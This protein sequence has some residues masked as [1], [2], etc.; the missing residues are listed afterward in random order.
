MAIRIYLWLAINWMIF[1]NSL[2][3]GNVWK[4]PKI[5]PSIISIHFKLFTLPETNIAPQNGRLEDQF[6]FGVRP[7]FMGELLVSGRVAE[8]ATRVA[9]IDSLMNLPWKNLR[10]QRLQIPRC[11]SKMSSPEGLEPWVFSQSEMQFFHKLATPSLRF[12]GC[13]LIF[14]QPPLKNYVFFSNWVHLPQVFRGEHNKILEVSPPSL[15]SLTFLNLQFL[16][17]LQRHLPLT[18]RIKN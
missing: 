5:H 9:C 6:P 11:R 1:T 2:P 10:R 16:K 15:Y 3:I 18:P 14:H 12:V 17:D 13:W 4:S 8:T 7:I